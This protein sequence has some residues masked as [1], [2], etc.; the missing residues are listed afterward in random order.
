[1]GQQLRQHSTTGSSKVTKSWL[2]IDREG[3][4]KLMEGRP[5]SFILNELVSNAWD[6]A[7]REVKITVA[8]AST[9]G[10][11]NIYVEDDNP[12][13]FKNL[14]HAYTLFAESSKKGNAEQRGRF[15]LGEKLVLALAHKAWIETTT[16]AIEFSSDGRRPMHTK[17]DRGSLVMV[18]IKATRDETD[19]I[20]AAAFRLIPPPGI[21]TTVN[22]ELI[23]ARH[24]FTWFDAILPTVIGDDEGVLRR[25][26]R[27]TL[28]RVYEPRPGETAM[29]Y[30][31]GIPVVETGDRF[32]VDV[33]QKVP[34]NQERDNV[35]PAFLRALRVAVL[36]STHHLIKPAEATQ[37][38]VRDAC[39]DARV[40][41]DALKTII[42][43]RFGENAV[44]Y[45]PSDR[46]ANKISASEDRQIVHGG[47][48][49]AGEWSNVRSAGLLPPAGKVTPSPKPYDPDGDTL[50]LIPRA[51]WTI[52]MERVATFAINIARE[53]LDK[54]IIVQIAHEPEWPVQAVFGKSSAL[55][56]NKATLSPDFFDGGITEAVLDLLIHE[57]GHHWT[58][59]HLSREYYDA[60]TRLGARMTL[61]ALDKPE[62][63]R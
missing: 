43:A 42:H 29:I 24:P 44:A 59:D 51:Q 39:S 13:G 63:F 4:A 19:D 17:R 32:H 27:K 36:N 57:F 21:K 5:K 28:V 62:L 22:G 56:F 15:N 37:S 2:E 34:L 16:G 41:P 58:I 61:L 6:G 55:V 7:T 14:S 18:E 26:E 1:M 8:P 46:E 31:L 49:S 23:E 3:L 10:Y 45:D 50:T 33:Q 35:T 47:S 38:W 25:S 60:L 40:T 11:I 9:R 54:K 48:L 20:V 52:G 53:L 12:E 30:E